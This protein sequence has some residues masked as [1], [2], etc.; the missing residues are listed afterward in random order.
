M[1][2]NAH[3]KHLELAA[4]VHADVPV[5]VHGDPNRLRQV[6][7]NLVAN[8]IKFTAQG[9]VILTVACEAATEQRVV[10]HFAIRDTGIGIPPEVQK[11]LFQPFMQA[12]TSTTRRYG[13][14]GLGLAISRTLV[15]LMHGRI[16]VVSEEG[17]GATFHFTIRFDRAREAGDSSPLRA[18]SPAGARVLVVDGQRGA[19]R[20][21]RSTTQSLGP[22]TDARQQC[23]GSA[24]SR[25]RGG[26][27]RGTLCPRTARRRTSRRRRHPAGAR[28]AHAQ[29]GARPR[30]ILLAGVGQQF[31]D[32]Q[33]R[34]A[35]AAAWVTKP[36]RESRLHDAVAAVLGGGVGARPT[37]L[38]FP[39]SQQVGAPAKSG[40]SGPA[41]H[42]A[43]RRQHH[44]PTDRAAWTQE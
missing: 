5:C 26:C 32:E 21:S 16:G 31:E 17:K 2:G 9:E 11:R 43:G 29:S 38:R 35:G 19:C 22:A 3:A 28:S 36:V 23:R 20:N 18:I 33:L 1:A 30:C 42:P 34:A 12:D 37:P 39:A 6:L 4:H 27:R 13:G 44:Q 8:A 7:N 41:A 15:E 10:L 14:T 24:A 25:Q 40:A